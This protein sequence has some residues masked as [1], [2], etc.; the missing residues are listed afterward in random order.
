MPATWVTASIRKNI[1]PGSSSTRGRELRGQ[2]R[3]WPQAKSF[4]TANP[5]RVSG[6][7]RWPHQRPSVTSLMLQNS[8]SRAVTCMVE[9][10]TRSIL[11]EGAAAG[12]GGA[13]VGGG[14]GAAAVHEEI[15]GAGAAG[16]AVHATAEVRAA[17]VHTAKNQEDS[18][19]LRMATSHLFWHLQT[20]TMTARSCTE[21][22]PWGMACGLHSPLKARAQ[23]GVRSARFHRRLMR[24]KCSGARPATTIC[25]SN[26]LGTR[27][28]FE[29]IAVF[30]RNPQLGLWLATPISD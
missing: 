9:A 4:A 20:Q 7:R 11:A 25:A 26:A 3:Q 12:G 24:L 18:T 23:S 30:F 14:A 2:W 19:W 10:E 27:C 21:L 1:L 5:S 29:A 15:G 22:V 6:G 17:G 28:S 8:T 13:A 16:A